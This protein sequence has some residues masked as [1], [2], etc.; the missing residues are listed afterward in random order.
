MSSTS[1]EAES[2]NSAISRCLVPSMISRSGRADAVQ[3]ARCLPPSGT[4][5]ADAAR[6]TESAWVNEA[7]GAIRATTSTC[8]SRGMLGRGS[9]TRESCGKLNAPR[10]TPITTCL[11]PSID[12]VCPSACTSDPNPRVA[13]SFAITATREPASLARSGRPTCTGIPSKEKMSP[14][15]SAAGTRSA[16]PPAAA[17]T[18]RVVNPTYCEK[19]SRVSARARRPSTVSR[20]RLDPSG[21]M[22]SMATSFSGSAKGS[23][24]SATAFSTEKQVVAAPIPSASVTMKIRV[25]E[26]CRAS[27][28]TA[29]RRS[30]RAL[31][32][33]RWLQQCMCRD[34]RACI[35]QS[36]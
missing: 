11:S 36:A 19:V 28:R 12:T 15:I 9:H 7:V 24:R 6:T 32:I 27:C 13:S 5:D 21:S 25:K 31:F 2:T 3:P 14:L 20:D 10:A 16:P 17:V 8:R 35:V 30:C 1:A 23:G 18:N 29:T 33:C 34:V 22:T 26:G 4:S